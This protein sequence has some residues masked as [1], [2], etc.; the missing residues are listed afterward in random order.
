MYSTR[1][2]RMPVIALVFGALL[3]A[4]LQAATI[5][6]QVV[7]LGANLHRYDYFISGYTFQQ[8]Q[9]LDI[10]FDPTQY[11]TL[12]KGVAPSGFNLL[13]LQP[14]NPPGG[15]GLYSAT[16][17]ANSP[18][19]GGTFSVDFTFSGTGQPA[20]QP[21]VIGYFDQSGIHILQS[22]STAPIMQGIPEPNSFLLGGAGLLIAGIV[23]LVRRRTGPAACHQ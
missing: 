17:L 19:L 13:L 16:A 12:S 1:V 8:G 9:E 15:D 23:R 21:F 20:A 11:G 6:F 4:T 2:Q 18:S 22:G 7:D 14:N 10:S 5:Q 3:G